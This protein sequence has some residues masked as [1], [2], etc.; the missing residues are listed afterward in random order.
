MLNIGFPELILIAIVAL[1]VVG[2]S[3]LPEVARTVGK[4]LGEFRRMADGVKESWQEEISK[5]NTD[6]TIDQSVDG[7]ADNDQCSTPESATNRPSQ[8]A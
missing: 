5:E 7:K 1:L 6:K 4:A 8:D 3:K 2:P